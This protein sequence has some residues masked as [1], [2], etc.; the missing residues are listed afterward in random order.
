MEISL[1]EKFVETS[2]GII[3]QLGFKDI[4]AFIKNQALIMMLAKLDK[5]ESENN[6]FERKYRMSFED[7]QR[8]IEELKDDEDFEEDNDYLDWRFAKEA[9][10]GLRKQKQ[11]LE[12][13]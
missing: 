12:H 4:K 3:T 10:N 2:E 9:I 7:F 5:Y 8:K 1:D 6:F 13:A 11:E